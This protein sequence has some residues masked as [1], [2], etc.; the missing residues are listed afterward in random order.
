L[1]RHAQESIARL[2]SR[3][4]VGS[5]AYMAPEQET[6]ASSVECD[7]YSLGICLYEAISGVLPYQGPDFHHQKMHKSYQ[8]LSDMMPALPRGVDALV[9]KCLAPAPEER[10]HSAEEFRSALNALL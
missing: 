10:F 9:A 4:V 6:G 2:A 1:A 3:E 5:P 7:I 8:P